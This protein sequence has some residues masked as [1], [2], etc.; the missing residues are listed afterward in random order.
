MS[1]DLTLENLFR[2]AVC[3]FFSL[4][5][6][7]IRRTVS[8]DVVTTTSDKSMLRVTKALIDCQE[9]EAI[10]TLDNRIR[11]RVKDFTLRAPVGLG[12]AL[13]PAACLEELDR[14]I[15]EFRA[16]RAR[17]IDA[18]CAA[19]PERMQQARIRLQHLFNENEYP[20]LSELR[21][22][23]CLEWRYVTFDLPGVL[24][25]IS[26]TMH[27][28]EKEKMAAKMNEIQDGI[29]V[30][31]RGAM[32]ELVTHLHDRLTPSADGK[33]KVFRGSTVD[34]LLEFLQRFDAKNLSGDE[35]LEQLVVE[36]RGLLT[37][38]KPE[39]LRKDKLFQDVVR[40][41][42]T[43]IKERLDSLLI[44]KPTRR[45]YVTEDVE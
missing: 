29:K 26:D 41:G 42:L 16:E 2:R 13:I 37:G 18:F 40:S 32:A 14:V 36:A 1:E 31:L 33:A 19:Y 20:T 4:R 6:P 5:K 43:G 9:Y 8:T 44:P 3:L 12:I 28:R 45:I 30:S 24:S 27:E 25:S 17:L 7:G 21:D 15:E 34:N 38:V 23:F 35:E 22:S 11:R 39:S 10:V